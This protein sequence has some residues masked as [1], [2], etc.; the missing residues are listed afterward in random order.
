MAINK[1]QKFEE[2]SLQIIYFSKS[3]Q[4]AKINIYESRKRIYSQCYTWEL[5]QNKV[6]KRHFGLIPALKGE[7]REKQNN[8]LPPKQ[9]TRNI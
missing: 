8:P 3:V 7:I 4:R 5:S 1:N 2:G 9:D 6:D